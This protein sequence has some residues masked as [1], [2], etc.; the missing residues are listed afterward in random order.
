MPEVLHHEVPPDNNPTHHAEAAAVVALA[1]EMDLL[2]VQSGDWHDPDTWGGV[3]PADGQ[4]V[5]IGKE[6]VVMLSSETARLKSLCVDGDLSLLS[7]VHLR[8]GTVIVL[9][10]GVLDAGTS[11]APIATFAR[12]TFIDDGPIDLQKDPRQLSR[13]LIALGKVTAH[14]KPKL[15]WTTAADV[16]RTNPSPAPMHPLG[17]QYG[18]RLDASGDFFNWGGLQDKWLL[19]NSGFWYFILPNGEFYR[20]RGIGTSGDLLDTIDPAFHGERF[21]ELYTAQEQPSNPAVLTLDED[22]AGW[23]VGDELLV[24]GTTLRLFDWQGNPLNSVEDEVVTVQ[25]IDGRNI[26][27]SGLAWD[28]VAAEGER[29]AVGNLTNNVEF[30]SEN[31]A[32]DR[33]GHFMV[34]HNDH[35]KIN[36]CSFID[37]GRTD[38]GRLLDDSG[39]ANKRGRYSLHFHRCGFNHIVSSKGLVVR[40]SPGW[41]VV[42][43]SSKV[44]FEDCIAYDCLGAGLVAE[45]GDEQGE[46]LHCLSVGGKGSGEGEE[47]TRIFAGDFGHS[48]VGIHLQ[49]P[50]VK[51]SN[52]CFAG[53]ANAAISMY[54]EGY[55]EPDTQ[56]VANPQGFAQ[57]LAGIEDCWGY[58]CKYG[59][60]TFWLNMGPDTN[61]ELA[62]FRRLRF[63][64]VANGGWHKYSVVTYDGCDFRGNGSG[65]G[66]TWIAAYS[67]QGKVVS[68]NIRGFAVGTNLPRNPVPETPMFAGG[69]WEND[70]DFELS[71]PSEGTWLRNIADAKFA[72]AL[73][74]DALTR[75]LIPNQAHWLVEWDGVT[76]EVYAPEQARD[77]VPFFFKEDWQR[78]SKGVAEVADQDWTGLSNQQI[79]EQ[80]GRVPQS[81]APAGVEEENGYLIGEPFGG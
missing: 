34:M 61:F 15:T 28:H 55:P 27:V 50:G 66:L 73:W 76:L 31:P 11:T 44:K 18:L 58:N 79:Y 63:W 81:L 32:P 30:R 71:L 1:Q 2:S 7:D 25:S 51:V 38:K 62:V 56:K 3:I 70:K 43:H 17:Q 42:N 22:P 19:G 53:H 24:P 29:I 75:Y 72:P 54:C 59:V 48:G 9:H 78:Q 41:G 47:D 14:G 8:A 46:F 36:Y 68:T 21:A 49:G 39:S 69:L 6:H 67:A 37:M 5:C 33:R 64:N 20:W 10:E 77:Y 26:T 13:G 4:R 40:G 45:A 35:A 23:E 65:Q 74:T 16:Y 60:R 12:I 57:P 80:F 52:C